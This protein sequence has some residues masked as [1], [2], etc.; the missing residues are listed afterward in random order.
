MTAAPL[1]PLCP[2]RQALAATWV[3][4]A[5]RAAHSRAR[6]TRRFDRLDDYLSDALLAVCE[7]AAT[8]D[9]S[10]G[11][12]FKTW[13]GWRLRGVFTRSWRAD[14]RHA[15]AV[16]IPAGGVWRDR[17]P[18]RV[19]PW[20]AE[21]S[22]ASPAPPVRLRP[23]GS[24]AAWRPAVYSAPPPP[25][26]RPRRAT[27]A[28][29]PISPPPSF[30]AS[31][32]VPGWAMVGRR[33]DRE[34]E[35]FLG[36]YPN[37]SDARA[38]ERAGLFDFWDSRGLPVQY[39]GKVVVPARDGGY[40]GGRPGWL[41]LGFYATEGEARAAEAAALVRFHAANRVAV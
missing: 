3:A 17:R 34:V 24:P 25:T 22:P 1:R 16:P 23:N 6:R 31:I 40:R 10:R 26:I 9:D 13:L 7:A 14:R 38:A 30:S 36:C 29:R 8:F 4:Y 5:E 27:P 2:A 33:P 37:E 20:V 35:V 39:P 11:A 19:A 18:Y 21:V 32:L 28:P 12:T 41:F 15:A